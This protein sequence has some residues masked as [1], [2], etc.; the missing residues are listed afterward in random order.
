MNELGKQPQSKLVRNLKFLLGLSLGLALAAMLVGGYWLRQAWQQLPAVE[1]LAQYQPALPLRIYSSEGILL[2][3]YGEE[4]REFLPLE[5]IPPVMRQAL[6][7]IE[8]ARFYEHGA[9]DFFGLL[10]ATLANVV[11]GQHA[12]GAS[13]ITMQ[14]AR[15]FFLTRDKTMQ[16]KLMEILMAYK[17]EQRYSKDKL[18]ELYMNQIYLGERSYGFAAASSIYFDKPLEQVTVAEAAMLAGLPKAPSAYNPVANPQR[19]Q[20]RQH[21]ILQRMHE[22]GYITADQLQQ[23]LAEQ[24][25]VNPRRNPSVREAAYAVEQARQIVMELYQ[26][27]AYTSG[28]DVTTTIRMAPQMAADK[29]LRTGLIEAQARRGYR[30][31]EG[32]LSVDIDARESVRQLRAAYPDSGELRAALV[33]A[34]GPKQISALLRDGRT[35][36]I[37]AVDPRFVGGWAKLPAS[38]KRSIVPGSVIRAYLDNSKGERWLLGQMP[39]MEGALVSLDAESGDILALA[40]GFDF[41]RNPFDHAVQAFRQP[42]SSFK[43]FVY[44][45]ALEKGY[46]PGTLVDDAQR[47]LR[48]AET[49]ARAW[50]PRNYGNNYEGFITVRRGL[51]RSKNLVAVSLMQA[52]GAD[53]VQQY[54]TRFGFLAERNPVSLPLALGAGAVTPLQL[55]QS[56]AAFANGGYHTAPRLIK[57][58]N[59]RSGRVLYSDAGNSQTAAQKSGKRIISARNA[60]VM[61]SMLQ[62]VVKSGTGHGAKVL[63]RSD[64]AGKTGTSNNA[65][66]AWFAGYSS[67]VVS[68]VWLGYDQPK[69]LGATTGGA[70]ALPIWSRYMQVALEGRPEQ[71]RNEPQGLIFSDGDYVYSEYLNGSCL[72]DGNAFIQSD[73]KCEPDLAAA[74][75]AADALGA[76]QERE[77]IL[78]LFSTEE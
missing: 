55:A 49:G 23:A 62:D 19:A 61:D 11:T 50:R 1:H 58:I 64:T 77:Q 29:Q 14:V 20:V 30:G 33:T 63:G 32:S 9:V 51:M 16:R 70:L 68:V 76:A 39:E 78:K 31:P 66:D 41:S 42:G 45:A 71:I 56:Y 65:Y 4:R 43:P 10:R 34:V 7:A 22:L 69:S 5:Q 12:Q 17:L 74:S 35:I 54:A 73:F 15:D 47:V 72:E 44:S 48:P 24:L 6:L 27:R 53:Y 18:L 36:Q 52:A 40:G 67:G 75:P 57:Q 37:G 13:T 8:D 3:E 59:D 28:L 26:E 25:V 60:F 2:A 46:F 21:Y 38:G